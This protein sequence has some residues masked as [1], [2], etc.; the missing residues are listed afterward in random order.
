MTIVGFVPEVVAEIFNRSSHAE[1]NSSG[2]IFRDVYTFLSQKFNVTPSDNKFNNFVEAVTEITIAEDEAC[3]GSDSLSTTD[4]PRI[5]KKFNRAFSA[6]RSVDVTEVR[7]LYG[8]M[9]CIKRQEDAPVPVTKRWTRSLPD[10]G[11]DCPDGRLETGT[12]KCACQFFDCLDPGVPETIFGFIEDKIVKCIAFVID[13]TG[14]MSGEIAGAKTIIKDFVGIE[15]DLYG[16]CY[17]LVPFNDF[18]SA[19]SSK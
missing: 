13:T 3:S 14:S 5:V 17:L 6:G 2:S 12:I 1:Y 10:L 9:L 8:Q 11:C 16:G 19:D 18:G 15:G 7:A 4:I